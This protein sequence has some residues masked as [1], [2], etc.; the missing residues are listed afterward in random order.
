M[1]SGLGTGGHDQPVGKRAGGR[2]Q[3]EHDG[4]RLLPAYWNSQALEITLVQAAG[5]QDRTAALAL[6]HT[7]EAFDTG[8][9]NMRIWMNAQ[10]ILVPVP[11]RSFA[12]SRD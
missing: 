5:A 11:P 1:G 12:T 2:G 6:G 4:A 9:A 10:E 3:G 7:V 8:S